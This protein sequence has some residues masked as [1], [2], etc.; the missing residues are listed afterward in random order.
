MRY[1]VGSKQISRIKQYF[2]LFRSTASEQSKIKITWGIRY[3]IYSYMRSEL[4][5]GMVH[6]SCIYQAE[7]PEFLDYESADEARGEE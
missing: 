3:K 5:S 1:M 2:Y 4:R 6:R 7:L